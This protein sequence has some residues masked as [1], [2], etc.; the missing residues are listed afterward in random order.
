MELAT[1]TKATFWMTLPMFLLVLL[2]VIGLVY[3][4]I[5]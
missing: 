2:I 5:G 1:Y 3:D 4:K